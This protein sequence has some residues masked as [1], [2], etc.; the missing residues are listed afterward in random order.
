MKKKHKFILILSNLG[1][2]FFI[3]NIFSGI[4]TFE[5]EKSNIIIISICCLFNCIIAIKSATT[6]TKNP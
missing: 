3:L 1:L 5:Y 2:F 4:I 6:T